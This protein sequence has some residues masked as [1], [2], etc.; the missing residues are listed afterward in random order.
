MDDAVMWEPWVLDA[1]DRC[2]MPIL[3]QFHGLDPS[4]PSLPDTWIEFLGQVTPVGRSDHAL[5][6]EG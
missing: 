3:E 2:E 1:R 5:F 4:S 6:I